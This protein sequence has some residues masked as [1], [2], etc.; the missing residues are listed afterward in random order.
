MNKLARAITKWTRACDKRLARLIS[1]IHHTCEFKQYCHV[2]STEQ[3]CRLCVYSGLGFCRRSTRL[4]IN[5]RWTLV[6]I[7]KSHVRCNKLDVQETDFSF[8]QFHRS[9]N[10]FS[11]CR[12]TLEWIPALDLW[13]LVI[14]VC[15]S[16]PN[17]LNN[18]KDQV[19][20]N[21]SR[22]TT[23]NKHTQNQTKVP[24]Q[25]DNFDV[26][27][28]DHVPSN[29]KFS[30]FG[31]MLYIFKDNEAVIE[32]IIKG[33][34]PRMRHVSRTHRVA[35]DWLFD[36]INLDSKIEIKYVDS[37]HQ[38]GDIL[39]KENFTRDE[40]NNL[41]RLFNISDS[42][43]LCCAQNFQLD[44]LHLN[45]GEKDARTERRQQDRGKIKA[46]DDEPGRLCWTSSSTVNSLIVSKSL[47]IR[48]APCRTDWSSTRKPDAKEDDQ[49][50]A[51]NSQ[52]WQKNAVLDVGTRKLVATEEDK[53]PE[54][55]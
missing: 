13:D 2:G 55:S 9:R 8:T 6:Y 18:S 33:R 10:N 53:E 50:A 7:R 34:S 21:S 42:S 30:R 41:L 25:H 28:V 43:F 35:L 16:S 17:G 37:K 45:D 40:W 19:R 11:R 31:A 4:K 12:F 54:L 52:G 23:S 39:T 32:M 20:G 15:H 3:Q 48:K 36:R 29:A 46:D 44:K 49:D 47:G 5:I 38:F 26:S 1:C 27:D 22:N 51:S 14:E 24:T